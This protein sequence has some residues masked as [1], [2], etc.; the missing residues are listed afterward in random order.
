MFGPT[1]EPCNSALARALRTLNTT[2]AYQNGALKGDD[3]V[4]KAPK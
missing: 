3:N 4:E 2:P 1:D